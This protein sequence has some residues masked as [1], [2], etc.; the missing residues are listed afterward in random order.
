MSFAGHARLFDQPDPRRLDFRASLSNVRAEW[1]VRRHLQRSSLAINAIVDVSASMHFG[2][3]EKIAI[4]AQFLNSLGRSAS[5]YGD[6]IRLMAFD[7]SFREDL[8]MPS[9]RGKALG[10]TMANTI[11][12]CLSES[13]SQCQAPALRECIGRI[14]ESTSLTFL[15]SDFHTLAES[16][17]STLS[18]LDTTLLVPMVLWADSEIN[19]PETG[20]WLSARDTGR[21]TLHHLWLNQRT[22]NQW[23]EKVAKRRIQ[24]EQI[25]NAHHANAFFVSGDFA[26]SELSSYFLERVA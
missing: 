19:P 4:A 8:F 1:L 16:L 23:R 17:D 20:H 7:A 22:R 5:T 10:H 25:F 15:I 11:T 6:S 24:L 12:A 26:A 14:P 18:E 13:P 21:K 2:Q 3:P 9:S